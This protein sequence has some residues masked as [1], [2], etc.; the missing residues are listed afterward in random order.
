MASSSAPPVPTG[1]PRRG[2][3]EDWLLDSSGWDHPRPAVLVHADHVG[4]RA[5]VKAKA[6]RGMRRAVPRVR[7]RPAVQDGSYEGRDHPAAGIERAQAVRSLRRRSSPVRATPPALDH[8]TCLDRHRHRAPLFGSRACRRPAAALRAARW[9]PWRRYP[10]RAICLSPT[11]GHRVERSRGRTV[12]PGPAG[13]DKPFVR[14]C[15]G[16]RGVNARHPAPVSDVR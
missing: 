4:R 6:F 14:Q 13:R 8:R 2:F 15:G 11:T 16:V 3:G 10:T 5:G 9:A 7:L 12:E 1:K